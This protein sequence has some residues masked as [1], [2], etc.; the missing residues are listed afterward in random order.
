MFSNETFDIPS[1]R[2]LNA[3]FEKSAGAAKRTK[4]EG[5][6]LGGYFRRVARSGHWLRQFQFNDQRDYRSSLWLG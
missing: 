2:D 4:K 3:F 1:K 6:H 5:C